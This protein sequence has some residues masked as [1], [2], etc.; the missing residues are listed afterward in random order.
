MRILASARDSRPGFRPDLIDGI[1]AA[2]GGCGR[3]PTLIRD[4]VAITTVRAATPWRSIGLLAAWP[5]GRA[6]R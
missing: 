1:Q 5:Y 6:N 4:Q 2:A 3:P